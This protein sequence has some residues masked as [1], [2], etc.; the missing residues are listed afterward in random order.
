MVT[1]PNPTGRFTDDLLTKVRQIAR[2]ILAD[3][4]TNMSAVNW[5]YDAHE[6]AAD[7]AEQARLPLPN[8]V[9]AA[10]AM[11]PRNRWERNKTMTEE[12]VDTGATAG[13]KWAIDRAI[14]ALNGKLEAVTGQKVTAF[15]DN[16]LNPDTSIAVTLDYRMIK[17]LQLPYDKYLER[18]GVYDACSDGLRDVAS[19]MKLA[20]HELQAAIWVAT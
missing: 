2:T 9:Y 15:A 10:A 4:D 8:V 20:P 5:Y 7:L 16:I 18:V 6:W 12:L 13:F 14:A 1:Y 3:A 17:V 19:D 11:S